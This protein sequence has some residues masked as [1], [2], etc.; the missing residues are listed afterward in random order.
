MR[1]VIEA[2][3]HI[4][5][6]PDRVHVPEPIFKVLTLLLLL[7]KFPAV[8]LYDTASKVP[9]VSVR[10]LIVPRVNA[11]A[12]VTIPVTALIVKSHS[13]TKPLLVMV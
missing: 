12:R 8:T 9:P 11:S 7:P 10:V 13:K 1:F 5:P 4:V 2:E 6:V 3:P